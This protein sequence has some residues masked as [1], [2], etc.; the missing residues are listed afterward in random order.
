RPSHICRLVK[1]RTA[2][3]ND[4]LLIEDKVHRQRKDL[5]SHLKVP[6]R[7]KN[8]RPRDLALRHKLLQP[9]LI[10]I[11]TDSQQRK[12]RWIELLME[13]L[14]LRHFSHAWSAPRRPEIDENDL[15]RIVAQSNRLAIDRSSFEPFR[16][17]P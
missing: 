6:C 7:I 14:E 12:L 13:L 9:L 8:H 2:I 5:P 4:M 10:L 1:T 16:L 17:L 11:H 3:A 15:S